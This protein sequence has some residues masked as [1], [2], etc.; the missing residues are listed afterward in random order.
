MTNIALHLP[1]IRTTSTGN[2]IC[3]HNTHS[4][5]STRCS[6]IEMFV[7][8]QMDARW[9]KAGQTVGV[10]V[11][12]FESR[13]TTAVRINEGELAPGVHEMRV[14]HTREVGSYTHAD[15]GLWM[16]GEGRKSIR[17]VIWNYM[18]GFMDP[19][20]VQDRTK[21]YTHCPN[22]AHGLFHQRL[23]DEKTDPATSYKPVCLFNMI[24][25]KMCTECLIALDNATA[26]DY[27]LPKEAENWNA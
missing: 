9:I 11:V 3:D 23:M 10:T 14:F 19:R 27:G 22:P 1:R 12:P 26:D 24:F 5:P 16:P 6:A 18:A 8:E 17:T 21:I 15:L 25:E 20:D 7:E 4:T 13:T 2:L